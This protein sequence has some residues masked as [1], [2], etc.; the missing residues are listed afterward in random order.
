[1]HSNNNALFF[2]QNPTKIVR[3]WMVQAAVCIAFAI[4]LSPP[5]S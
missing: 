5:V 4:E 2:C 3:A 1:M